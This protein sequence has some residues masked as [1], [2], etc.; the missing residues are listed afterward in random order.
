MYANIL[1]KEEKTNIH[2]SFQEILHVMSEMK[3]KLYLHIEEV[4]KSYERAGDWGVIEG[5]EDDCKTDKV[6]KY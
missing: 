6:S 1:W 2:F 4:F 3:K 5:D